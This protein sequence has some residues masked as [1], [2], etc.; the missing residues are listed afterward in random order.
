MQRAVATYRN[1]IAGNGQQAPTP[2]PMAPIREESW[3][4]AQYPYT[5]YTQAFPI[6]NAF[7]ENF[8]PLASADFVTSGAQYEPIDLLQNDMAYVPQ[9]ESAFGFVEQEKINEWDNGRGLVSPQF[10]NEKQYE[11]IG[12]DNGGK[13]SNKEQAS[14]T[15]GGGSDAVLTEDQWY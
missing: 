11:E 3:Q 5:S 2:F 8:V 6:G 10:N 15:R 1:L 4:T 13:Y 7:Q 12:F 14:S 9:W